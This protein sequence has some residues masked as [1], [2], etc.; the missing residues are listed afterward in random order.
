MGKWDRTQAWWAHWT[1]KM[2]AETAS[3][4]SRVVP[5]LA[6]ELRLQRP[7]DSCRCTL[8]ASLIPPSLELLRIPGLPLG[9]IVVPCRD[10]E[11]RLLG[12]T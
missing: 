10:L 12:L 9:L 2:T 5:S 7:W 8:L 6:L 1:V 3:Q 4:G 11:P